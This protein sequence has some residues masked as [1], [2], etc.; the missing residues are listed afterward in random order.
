MS[1]SL[2]T[3]RKVH[4]PL[5]AS[6]SQSE[7][8]IV[9][10]SYDQVKVSRHNWAIYECVVAACRGIMSTSQ[11]TATMRQLHFNQSINQ[12]FVQQTL[13]MNKLVRCGYDQVKASQHN[14]AIYACVVAACQNAGAMRQLHFNQSINHLFNRHYTS[15]SQLDV[16]MTRLRRLDTIGR[17]THAL[18]RRAGG[19]CRRPKTQAQCA[20]FIWRNKESVAR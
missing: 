13:C 6:F 9:R 3:I 5:I 10:C 2:F 19:S 12:S 18:W 11:N 15:I 8:T 1:Y 4:S 16:G 14:W 20:N 7:Q 17:F